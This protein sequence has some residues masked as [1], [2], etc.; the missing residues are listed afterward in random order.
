MEAQRL[1]EIVDGFVLRPSLARDI[2]LATLSDKPLTHFP[3]RGRE[4][5]F[6]LCFSY[7]PC[8]TNGFVTSVHH[9]PASHFIHLQYI[10]TVVVD[11]LAADLRRL[12]ARLFTGL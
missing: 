5:L 12:I 11:H 10:I 3:N 4:A 1:L 7:I 6:R 9:C 8:S 2:D